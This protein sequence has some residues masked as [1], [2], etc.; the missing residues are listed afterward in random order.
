MPGIF[1]TLVLAIFGAVMD[2]TSIRSSADGQ[3]GAARFID[4]HTASAALLGGLRNVEL[5]TLWGVVITAIGVSVIART[6][7]GAGFMAALIKWL[8]VVAIS[9]V[10]ALLAG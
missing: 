7:R 1:S 3:I 8:I 5:F 9:V 2:T 10:P 4:P 6:S